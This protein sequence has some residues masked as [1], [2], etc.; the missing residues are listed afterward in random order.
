MAVVMVLTTNW[1]VGVTF[2]F[3][4]CAYFSLGLPLLLLV[5]GH[6]DRGAIKLQFGIRAILVFS[7][8]IALALASWHWT[9]TYGAQQ[10]AEQY[11]Q[12]ARQVIKFQIKE[13]GLRQ[14]ENEILDGIDFCETP[15]AV[16]PFIISVE[17][18][19]TFTIHYSL[20]ASSRRSQ[21]HVWFFGYLSD[22]IASYKL[23]IPCIIICTM[24]LAL[25]T[26]YLFLRWRNSS[27]MKRLDATN[28][29]A[30]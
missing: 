11:E 22:P 1:T 8:A 21:T 5:L 2:G 24:P 12:S 19:D 17:T 29:R 14:T 13:Y 6:N 15:R 3:L 9:N 25:L 4:S 10:L 20:K 26:L 16:L 7:G 28:S 18:D 30:V 27:R 23:I